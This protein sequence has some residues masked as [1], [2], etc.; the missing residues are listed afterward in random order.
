MAAA[1]KSRCHAETTTTAGGTS[2]SVT[3]SPRSASTRGLFRF[4]VRETLRHPDR[5]YVQANGRYH[6]EGRVYYV[7]GGFFGDVQHEYDF[8][9]IVSKSGDVVTAYGSY[10]RTLPY[11]PDCRYSRC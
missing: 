11:P 10:N 8:N 2:R 1:S 3:I 5:S 9:V 6:Y 7:V 4:A